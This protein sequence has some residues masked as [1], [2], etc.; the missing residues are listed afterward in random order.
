MKKLLVKIFLFIPFL[1]VILFTFYHVKKWR[2]EQKS[3]SKNAYI[4]KHFELT[5][6]IDSSGNTVQPG[7]AANDITLVDF[8]FRACP[9]C[10]DEMKQFETVLKG[11]EKKLTVISICIDDYSVWKKLFKEPSGAW[12]FL[13]KPVANWQHLVI[14]RNA[15]ADPSTAY[16]E[17]S[18]MLGEKLGVTSYPGIFV[19][20]REGKIIAIPETAVGFIKTSIENENGFIVFLQNK[21]TWVS[22]KMAL[23]LIV[24]VFLYNWIF[25]FLSGLINKKSL[26]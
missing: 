20:N 10:L 6:F 13:A 2:H 25:N 16:E 14:K 11:A 4:G 22:F 18:N 3:K 26:P 8:W 23:L 7:F 19:V 24:S 9:T 1:L 15:G 5:G 21:A 12:A 17:N